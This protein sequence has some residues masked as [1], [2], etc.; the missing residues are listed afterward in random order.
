MAGTLA[1]SA[2][3]RDRVQMVISG[4]NGLDDGDF[5]AARAIS[6]RQFLSGW[7]SSAAGVLRF[8]PALSG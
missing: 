5:F 1:A 3:G 2:V 7:W 8:A 6:N 4:E